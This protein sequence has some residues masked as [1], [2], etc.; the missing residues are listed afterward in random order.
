MKTII[1]LIII[2][3]LLF[4][5]EENDT[6]PVETPV[7]LYTLPVVVHIIH[8]GEDV[9]EG[10][11]LP[12]ERVREQIKSLN[13]DFRRVPGTLGEN[14]SPLSDDAFIQFKLAEIDPEGNPTNGIH[15]VNYFDA[16]NETDLFDKL[17]TI[18]YWNPEKYLNIW[19]YGGLPPN[20]LA[21]R[22][23]LPTTDLPGLEDELGTIG[24]AVMI[25]VHHFGKSDVEG[26][27]NLG[28]TLTHEMGHFLGLLHV[29]GKVHEGKPCLEFDDFV[30]DTPPVSNAIDCNGGTPLA[31]DGQPAPVNN[32]M[33]LTADK[34]LNMFT[35][36][37]IE[38]MRY[39][40]EN[41]VRRK[42]LLTSEAI[43]R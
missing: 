41:A 2:S 24:D 27:L 30:E 22:A 33:N 43:D 32:Y 38:R 20:T 14:N 19:V 29:W 21:G 25:N 34:C 31:C 26:P 5:C 16:E 42:S 10:A 17:P 7:A 13:D 23:S 35:K 11:N 40:L 28:K 1:L 3:G 18:A 36:G 8:S 12:E 15:R 39:V 9:G 4:S 6:P 37:Q